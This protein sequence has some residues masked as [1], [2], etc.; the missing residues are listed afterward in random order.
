MAFRNPPT[1][2]SSKSCAV[3]LPDAHER[4]GVHEAFASSGC[5]PQIVGAADV[6]VE[7][8]SG[9]TAAARVAR[10]HHDLVTARRQR[11]SDRASRGSRF[12]PSEG[13][14]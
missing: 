3:P 10:E 11:A 12:R 8:R 4:G 2:T 9:N 5:A 1:L 14:A 13:R 7:R 6:P